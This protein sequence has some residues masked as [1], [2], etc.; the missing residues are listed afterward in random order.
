[1]GLDPQD[2]IEASAKTIPVRRVGEPRDV[3]NVIAFL[4]SDDASYVSGQIIYVAGGPH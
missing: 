2:F 3:A 4:A 1:M